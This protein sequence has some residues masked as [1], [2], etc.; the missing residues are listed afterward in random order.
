MILKKGGDVPGHGF[1]HRTLD[2]TEAVGYGATTVV[3]GTVTGAMAIASVALA[4][5]GIGVVGLPV[6][7]GIMYLSAVGTT[8]TGSKTIHKVKHAA[9]GE[10][11]CHSLSHAETVAKLGF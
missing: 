8:Y 6:T 1:F 3:G 10:G 9:G 5:T 4:M 2:A 7:L 11:K